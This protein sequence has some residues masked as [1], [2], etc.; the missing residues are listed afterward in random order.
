MPIYISIL[1]TLL[2]LQLSANEK[3]LQ[4][5]SMFSIHNHL[6]ESWLGAI[7]KMHWN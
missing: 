4:N 6:S 2:Y 1:L 7:L 5:Y 3:I